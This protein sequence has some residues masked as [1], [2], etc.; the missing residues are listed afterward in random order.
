MTIR[1][2]SGGGVRG[3]TFP[4]A[5]P[6]SRLFSHAGLKIVYPSTARDAKGLLKSAIR[7]PD[8]VLFFEHKWLYRRPQLREVLPAEDYTIPLG[9]ARVH[10]EGAD[11]TVVTY[12]AMVHSAWKPPSSSR[13]RMAWTSRSSTCGLC[14][15]S[16][17]MPSSAA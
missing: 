1:G 3:R 15:R 10:R 14:F 9:E 7:D 13:R 16:T 4:L 2:P 11:L 12:A 5:E 17:R 8:P 6:G